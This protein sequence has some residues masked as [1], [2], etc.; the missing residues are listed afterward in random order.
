MIRICLGGVWWLCFGFFL[1]L[2]GCA[3]NIPE[4]EIADPLPP[5]I[6]RPS[7][8]I[9]SQKDEAVAAESVVV[10]S[11]LTKAAVPEPVVVESMLTEDLELTIAAEDRPLQRIIM[12]SA[13][14]IRIA[15]RLAVYRQKLLAWHKLDEQMAA[16]DFSLERPPGWDECLAK[17]VQIEDGYRS[18][19]DFIVNNA[20]PFDSAH[21]HESLTVCWLDIDY[22]QSNC[23]LVYRAGVDM[24]GQLA[25]LADSTDMAAMHMA[26]L[27][28]YYMDNNMPEQA[29]KSYRNLLM[30]YPAYQVDVAVVTAYLFALLHTEQME[31]AIGELSAIIKGWTKK[32]NRVISLQRLLAD[33]LL[34][35]GQIDLAHAQYQQLAE[36]FGLINSDEIWVREQLPLFPFFDDAESR[37][38]ALFMDIVRAHIIFDGR[39]VPDALS[40]VVARLEKKYPAGVLTNRARHILWQVEKEAAEWI[41]LR[42]LKVDSL[43]AQQ[44]YGQALDILN[45]IMEH[46][47]PP[48]V[49]RTVKNTK[50]DVVRAEMEE[51]KK[52]QLLL[53][54][55]WEMQWNEASRLLAL[56]RYDD[57]IVVFSL[58]LDTEY[59][60][61][62]REKIEQAANLAA[63]DMRRQAADLFVR[64]RRVLNPER[65]KELIIESWQL[66]IQ[67]PVKYPD[68][69]IIDK[70]LENIKILEEQIRLFDP[71]LLDGLPDEDAEAA[72]IVDYEYL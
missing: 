22:L 4:V 56:R 20:Q 44:E 35:T 31:V 63:N 33:M 27:V 12:S 30:I 23:A 32:D 57:A 40:N 45:K 60:V 59:D 36:F 50:D 14:F 24:L 26:D 39:Y 25:V 51:Q 38:L 65:K 62:S 68:V 11:M 53:E 15:A 67:I 9:E 3:A 17:I 47:L 71:S 21:T 29:I 2:S 58:L 42:L 48:A 1:L 10:E 41:D 49:S 19:H 54:Q 37:E 72:F 55:T 7:T 8:F 52:Q 43:V 18:I 69:D 64:A 5:L 66:L 46:P 13:D 16:A 34:A 28:I 61:E 6:T 70:V